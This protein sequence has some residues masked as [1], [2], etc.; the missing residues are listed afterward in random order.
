MGPPPKL[1]VSEWADDRR[2]LSSEASAEPGKWSTDRAPYQRGM[3]DA[4]NEDEVHTVVFMTSSQVGKTEILL[5]I[6]GYFVDQDPSPMLCLQP[7]TKPMGEAFS[8]DRVAP[9]F[10]D[11]PALRGKV[12]DPRSRDSSNT[13][14][15]KKFPGGHLTITGANSPAS[16]ASRP[17][18]VVLGDEIDRYPVSAG[19]EGDP[20]S[21]AKKRT[22]TFANRKIILTSTPTT[23]GASRIEM[24]WDESDQRFY[25]VPCPHCG[26]H[27]RLVWSNV[28]WQKD[29]EGVWDGEDPVYI[30]QECGS[31]IG[32]ADKIQML[33]AG[34]WEASR[35]SDGVAGFHLS[36]LYSP[37]KT[38][39][40]V[41]ADWYEAQKDTELLRVFVNT[42]LGETFEESGERVDGTGLMAR[43]EQY[44]AQ[45]PAGA[46]VLVAGVD[47]QD[48][49]LEA[50]VW[51]Y[52]RDDETWAITHRVMYGDPADDEVWA[53]LDA[54]IF[55]ER[56]TH[57]SGQAM[58]IAGTCIDSGGHHTQRVY[59]Y[60]HDPKRKRARIFAIKGYAGFGRRAVGAP[61]RARSGRDGRPVDLYTL[62]VDELKRLVA[63][64][65]RRLKAGPGYVH[66]PVSD[67]FEE[68]YFQ[69][70][71]A[72]ELR[73][74][75]VSGV[76][77]F[78]WHQLRDRNE[79]LDCAV[80]AH[81]ARVLINPNYDAL[82]ARI[83]AGA[84]DDAAPEASLKSPSR[85]AR[86]PRRGG[87]VNGWR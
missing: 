31:A 81:A 28:Q 56:F 59:G 51:G 10:R 57:E 48:D 83:G 7:N 70:L 40:E 3:M 11:T 43:R 38:W 55:A 76:P 50:T 26:E 22:T 1:T 49:R 21:L 32:E 74:K 82:E 86:R 85:P 29:D 75:I 68:D 4:L 14:L 33:R 5:N 17:I 20:L 2:V 35:Q 34:Q 46:L 63:G 61:S 24:A 79:A 19:S 9:M 15:H 37:W 16:L 54:L 42:S 27:Q 64:R 41:V 69:Q 39:R 8:K 84:G 18:R 23:K 66:F 44:A 6:L 78:Y 58:R 13:L 73:R 52:G 53:D 36:E 77:T 72:E 25:M 87:F 71:S 67:E 60:C 45:V 47:V 30:C 80:Y 62:G 65:L 12:S